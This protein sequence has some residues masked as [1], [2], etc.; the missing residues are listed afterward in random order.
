MNN[1]AK[2]VFGCEYS[3]QNP[4]YCQQCGGHE[5][6]CRKPLNTE[7]LTAYFDQMATDGR[8]ETTVEWLVEISLLIQSDVEK[9]L[10]HAKSEMQ[11]V[12]DAAT[13]LVAKLDELRER[14]YC[15]CEIGEL[16][17]LTTFKT[18]LSDLDKEN[19]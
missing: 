1:D 14:G 17:E 12:I 2:A 13:A 18:A 16:D 19:L 5:H 3:E 4:V 10:Q 15:S 11:G 8:V 6:L 7:G 9:R